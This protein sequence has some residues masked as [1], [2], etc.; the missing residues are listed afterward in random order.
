MRPAAFFWA[1]VP[2]CFEEERE[3][4]E[5]DFLPPRLEAPGEFAIR[6]ARS[7]DIPFS[8]SF[9]YCF[10]FFTLGRL[11]G[12]SRVFPCSERPNVPPRTLRSGAVEPREDTWESIGW[13]TAWQQPEDNDRE[14]VLGLA[15]RLAEQRERQRAEDL[16]QIEE[17]KRAL[18]E[19]AA[20]VAA[21]ELEVERRTRELDERSEGRRSLLRR[22]GEPQKPHEEADR[23]YAQEIL[24]RRETEL[25]QRAAAIEPREREVTER[26]TALR[27]RELRLEEA[28]AALTQREDE[29]SRAQSAHESR[30]QELESSF[31]RVR[32]EQAALTQERT[33]AAEAQTSLSRTTDDVVER[34]ATLEASERAVAEEREQLAAKLRELEERERELLKKRERAVSDSARSSESEQRVAEL[35]G[36]LAERERELQARES[37]VVRLQAGLAAQQ[38]SLRRRERALQDA[39]RERE[40]EA[41]RPV[42]PYVSFNEG[43]EALTGTRPRRNS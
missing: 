3:E 30:A 24:A 10:S 9:S 40:R 2:P 34:V 8:L 19:R 4:L 13:D 5:W 43:L 22:R 37:E 21:R 17:L 7:F 35:E 36:R 38:E 23:A 18:R 27:A 41:V 26:E 29:L 20:D 42:A 25:Q 31:A 11:L 39:E 28:E 6:A 1:V 33:A 14:Q 32:E 15:R 16:V 12:M